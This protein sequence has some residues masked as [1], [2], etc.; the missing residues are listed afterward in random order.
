MALALT[1]DPQPARLTDSLSSTTPRLAPHPFDKTGADVVLRSCDLVDFRV[2]GHILIEASPV[3]ESMLS[4]PQPQT[5]TEIPDTPVVDLSEDSG[6]I[7]TLLRICYPIRNPALDRPLHELEAFLRAAMKYDMELPVIVLTDCVLACAEHTPLPVW[8]LACRLQL[9][10]VARH[11][12][13]HL[14]SM[15]PLDFASLGR[16]DGI[17]AGD[18]FRLHEFLRTDSSLDAQSSFLPPESPASNLQPRATYVWPPEAFP[19]DHLPNLICRSSDGVDLHVHRDV[20]CANSG[21]F[22]AMV[23][24]AE[25]AGAT[26]GGASEHNVRTDPQGGNLPVIHVEAR[27]GILAQL[28]RFCYPAMAGPGTSDLYDI[29]DLLFLAREYDMSVVSQ[30][31]ERSWASAAKEDPL[32]AYFAAVTR[33]LLGRARDAAKDTLARSLDG[34]YIPELEDAPAIVYHRLLTYHASCRSIA[35]EVLQRRFPRDPAPPPVGV[36]TAAPVASPPIPAIRVEP[37]PAS[38]SAPAVSLCGHQHGGFKSSKAAWLS[39]YVSNRCLQ[40]RLQ[41][42]GVDE[43]V[44]SIL[45]AAIDAGLWCRPCK[46]LARDVSKVYNSLRDIPLV[47][48]QVRH[49]SS[50]I[51]SSL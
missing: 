19:D 37:D 49:A 4:L 39:E 43:D 36:P 22:L 44:S 25:D 14:R 33:G 1:K 32:R 47:V 35:T 9:E 18:Y 15:V 8:A 45:G 20:L 38:S 28:F 21:R 51:M 31:V 30:V 2:R 42:Y 3:F 26:A 16:M 50:A 23:D 27:A 40:A 29:A 46:R 48:S 12:A 7:E 17:C 41:P 13:R 5:G 34:F 6:T 10:D 24:A 11:A